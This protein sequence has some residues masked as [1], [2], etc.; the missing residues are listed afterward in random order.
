[1]SNLS[2]RMRKVL[3]LHALVHGAARNFFDRRLT[4]VETKHLYNLFILDSTQSLS[5]RIFV[6][7]KTIK[8]HRGN[9]YKSINWEYKEGFKRTGRSTI[10]YHSIFETLLNLIPQEKF[11]ELEKEFKN[12]IKLFDLSEKPEDQILPEGN[13]L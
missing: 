10:L 4:K 1:M 8:F 5:D 6:A 3:L 13:A 11:E 2:L 7:E 12:Q 9:I